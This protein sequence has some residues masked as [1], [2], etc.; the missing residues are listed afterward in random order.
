MSSHS[1]GL[2]IDFENLIYGLV[3]KY[4]EQGAYETFKV[5]LLSEFAAKYGEVCCAFA[6][7]DWRIKAVNQW[8]IDLY[9]RGVELVH[10]LGRG[11]KN[12]VDIR[13]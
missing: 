4:G 11:G 6:Y 12:A 9:G 13:I 3:D 8:Q 10:V 7:A 1:I 2:F 5:H